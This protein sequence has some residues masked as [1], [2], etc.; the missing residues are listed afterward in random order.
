MPTRFG[1]GEFNAFLNR[2]PRPPTQDDTTVLVGAN[3]RRA[4]P[5]ELRAFAEEL[6]ASYRAEHEDG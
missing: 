6:W 3:G 1:P 4:T 5:D 2:G